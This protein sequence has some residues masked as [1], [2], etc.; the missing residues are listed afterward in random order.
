MKQHE[1]DRYLKDT[2]QHADEQT[3][4]EI[5]AGV[6]LD[7]AARRRIADLCEQKLKGDAPQLVHQEGVG[8]MKHIQHWK[9]IL[10]QYKIKIKLKG[11]K[12]GM[13]KRCCLWLFP[14]R[15]ILKPELM[16]T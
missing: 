10:S 9:S 2:L 3:A 11:Q 6:P 5:I 4:S 16:G 15:I 7:A 1:F 14:L 13:K 8:Q 12:G